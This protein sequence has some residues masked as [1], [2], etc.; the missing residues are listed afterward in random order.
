MNKLTRNLISVFGLYVLLIFGLSIGLNDDPEL[1]RKLGLG[2]L[3]AGQLVSVL[4][5]VIGIFKLRSLIKYDKIDISGKNFVDLLILLM[6]TILFEKTNII[7]GGISRV[8]GN[9]ITLPYLMALTGVGVSGVLLVVLILSSTSNKK[10]KK[11]N[12]SINS[13]ILPVIFIA[14]TLSGVGI[15]AWLLVIICIILLIILISWLVVNN[16]NIRSD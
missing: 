3:A 4:G 11:K 15:A 9:S 8:D 5:L 10:A 14:L 13:S 2:I 1:S 6:L 7:I 12:V 16:V